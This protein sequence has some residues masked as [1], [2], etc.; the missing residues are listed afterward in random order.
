MRAF[1]IACALLISGALS[2][3][4]YCDCG[5]YG[6]I[7]A[8][9]TRLCTPTKNNLCKKTSYFRGEKIEG[10]K[11]SAAWGAN[12]GYNYPV[13]YDFLVSFEAGYNDNGYSEITFNNGNQYRI[14]STDWELLATGTYV[15]RPGVWFN[16]KWGAAKV[17][18]IYRIWHVCVNND[19]DATS[20]EKKWAPTTALSA[21]L[22][23][24][25]L[26]FYVMYRYVFADDQQRMSKLFRIRGH[27]ENLPGTLETRSGVSRLH[28]IQAG[29]Q[30]S[31]Y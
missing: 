13:C 1:S 24:C 9:W 31:L 27:E 7:H 15:W 20:V 29:V 8:G 11:G 17:R 10:C 23:F 21:G 14:E 18:Q 30:A 2:A 22:T 6:G 4:N 16:V 3:I 19:I 5:P 25:G 12:I 28:S 26:D